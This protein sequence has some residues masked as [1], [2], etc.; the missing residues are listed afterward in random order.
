VD[1]VNLLRKIAQVVQNIIM[2][3]VISSFFILHC[4]FHSHRH[5]VGMN[6]AVNGAILLGHVSQKVPHAEVAIFTQKFATRCLDA[7]NV[8][9]I[10]IS[11]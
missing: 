9:S 1:I 10:T 3:D 5:N 8:Q 6:L 11:A 4:F 7:N 2:Y